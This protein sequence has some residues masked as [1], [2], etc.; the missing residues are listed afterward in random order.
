MDQNNVCQHE[1]E[2][3][4]LWDGIDPKTRLQTG[5]KIFKCTKCQK[6]VRT[7]KELMEMG[8]TY[9]NQSVSDYIDAEKNFF[10]KLSEK[11]AQ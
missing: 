8:G 10:A 7:L 3:A 2:D 6:N 11:K 5:G 4:G 1:W 9:K